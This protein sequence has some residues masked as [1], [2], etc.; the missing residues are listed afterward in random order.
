MSGEPVACP[1]QGHRKASLGQRMVA[2]FCLGCRYLLAV[3]FLMAAVSKLI[4]GQGFREAVLLQSGLPLAVG[5]LVV[6]FLPWLE[7]TCGLC[8]ALGYAVREAAVLTSVLVLL[9]LGYALV[10]VT[11]ADCHCYF[12]PLPGE[13]TGS[14]W[15]L[16]RNLVLLGSGVIVWRHR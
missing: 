6:A 11:E 9:F 7:L 15:H 2:V 1:A 5:R 13:P 14:W 8:L 16:V 10:R 3:V 4:D 12:A